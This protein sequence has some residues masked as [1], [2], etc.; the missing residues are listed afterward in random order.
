M[1]ATPVSETRTYWNRKGRLLTF[2]LASTSIFCLLA[3]FYGLCSMRL[4][5]GFIFLP[6]VLMLGTISIMD[7]LWGDRRAWYGILIGLLAGLAAAVAYDLFRLPFVFAKAWGIDA[8]VPAM[9][10][11]KVF[12]RFGA[13]ILNEPVEQPTYRLL[14]HLVGWAYHFSN[15]ATFGV[16]FVAA[17]GQIGK[18]SWK[19]AILMAV[20][21]EVAMLAT[22]YTTQFGISLTTRFVIVTLTAHLIFGI[23][24][25][26]A[27]AGLTARV[28]VPP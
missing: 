14:S 24:M 3:D 17:V 19:W 11:F 28:R 12:P 27:G 18:G 13:M 23:A 21:L 8:I 25:A 4:A 16:M 26:V 15:G 10:L 2:L 20:G 7:R 5:T 22:P 9:N 1:T 6:A